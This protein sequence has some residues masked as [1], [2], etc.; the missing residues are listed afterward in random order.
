MSL[1]SKTISTGLPACGGDPILVEEHLVGDGA[2]PDHP[3]A[4]VAELAADLV[5]P[6]EREQARQRVAELEGVE[7]V[8]RGPV[9]RRDR[10]DVGEQGVERRAASSAGQSATGIR[11]IA[12]I[13]AARSEPSPLTNFAR[14]LNVSASLPRTE[15][16]ATIAERLTAPS[17]P[18]AADLGRGRLPPG[19]Q[20]VGLEDD[21]A[22]L[23]RGP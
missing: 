14:A 3:D 23:R 12:R 10:L 1:F 13:A 7:G 22:G 8:R 5:G 9:P 2:Q 11:E 6:V 21:V 19:R 18:V 4:E 17:S 15:V 16:S 20:V